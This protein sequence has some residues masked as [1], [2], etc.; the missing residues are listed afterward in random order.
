MYL[1]ALCDDETEQLH[2]T[3]K[4]LAEYRESHPEADLRVECFENAD[5]LLTRIGDEAYLPDLV[6]MDIYM[7]DILGIEAARELRRMG[8]HCRIVFLTTS[9]EHALDAFEVEAA[10]YLVKPLAEDKLSAVLDK[11]LMEIQEERKRF[12]LLQIDGTVQRVAV[13][14]IIYC[15]AQ[16]KFQYLHLSDGSQC[17]LRLTMTKLVELL[18]PYTEFMRVGV[19]Y[20]VNMDHIECVGKQEIRMDDGKKIYPPRNACQTVR[21]RYFA[22]YCDK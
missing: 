13:D 15:E 9:R 14:D 4:M 2:K 17:M 19:A 16:G 12:V 8:N 7:P 20:L 1:I 5:A 6:L 22:Y 10:Q 3:E 18:V 11:L 21:E